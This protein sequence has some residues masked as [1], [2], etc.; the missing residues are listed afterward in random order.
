M[1][2][3]EV[4]F[5]PRSRREKKP[6]VQAIWQYAVRL[7][8]HGQIARVYS[9]TQTGS[10]IRL[11]CM[12]PERC[13]LGLRFDDARGRAEL[14]R[15]RRLATRP[16]LIRIT[17]EA[18]ETPSVCRCRR[19]SSIHL[20]THMFDD[21][22]PLDCGACRQPIPFYRLRRLDLSM[23][24]SLLRWQWVYQACDELFMDSGFGEMWGYAQMSRLDSGLTKEGRELCTELEA[25]LGVPVFYYLHRYWGRDEASE[26][27]RHCPG[28]K[29][30]WLLPKSQGCFHF[31]CDKCRLLS[32]LAVGRSKPA[33]PPR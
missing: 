12:I 8:R 16:P 22:S 29:G 30:A 19:R 10:L 14:R 27:K 32:C 21:S 31:K 4:R 13:S 20:F 11:L 25:K 28:C 26:R 1:F 6:F 17:G 15:I 7:Y 33:K 3:A 2:H 24:E 5:V 23:R 9:V 18:V